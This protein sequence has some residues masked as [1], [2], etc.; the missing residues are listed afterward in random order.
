MES[1]FAKMLQGYQAFK[2]HHTRTNSSIMHELATQG[3]TSEIMIVA[4][5]DSRVDPA[6]IFQCN[7]GDLFTVRNVANI[8]PPYEN[9]KFHHGTSAALE[10]GICY[11]QVKHLIILGHSQ[12]AGISASLKQ[13]PLPQDDFISNWVSLIHPDQSNSLPVDEHAKI[14]LDASYDNCFTFPWIKQRVSENKLRIHRWFFD[15]QTASIVTYSSKLNQYIPLEQAD[16][17]CE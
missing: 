6:L 5:C 8:V 11:L 10:F 16:F 15:I 3:Q 17:T 2:K 9:D 13:S 1:S 12:C 4:C 7:P 14:A